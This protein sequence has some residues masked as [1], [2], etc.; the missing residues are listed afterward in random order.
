M[1]RMS[2][3]TRAVGAAAVALM[4]GGLIAGTAGSA[5]AANKDG[6]LN[7]GELIQWYSWN[8]QGGCEDDYSSDYSFWDD[9]F[10]DCGYG[11]SGVGQRVA[12]NS[13]SVCNYDSRYTAILYTGVGGTGAAGTVP[14][15]RCGNLNATFAD[16]VESLYWR[17]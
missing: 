14:P 6:V 8:Y 4:A 13:E 15:Y 9:Y 2:H 17:L 5:Q 16:N 1:N 3:A 12:N 11:S 10:K 7:A